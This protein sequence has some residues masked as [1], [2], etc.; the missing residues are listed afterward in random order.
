MR[1]RRLDSILAR[2]LMPAAWR[3]PLLAALLALAAHAASAQV[4]APPSQNS[5]DELL[6]AVVRLKT[7]VHPDARTAE[8]LG[9]ERDG[10]GIVIDSDGLIL[11]IGYLMVEAHAAQVIVN[12]GRVVPANVVGYDH[13][14]GFGLLRATE[15]LKVKPMAIGK[16]ADLKERDQ[17]LAASFGGRDGVAPAV[18]VSRREFVGAWEYLVDAAIFTAPTHSHWSGA[19]LISREGKLVGIGSLVVADA[20]GNG[21]GMA[22]NMYVPIDLLPPILADLIADGHAAGP[23]RPWIGLSTNELAGTLVVGRVTPGGPAEKAGLERGAVILAVA[24]EK[25]KDLADFYRKVWATGPAG[26]TVALDVAQNGTTRRIEI[27]SINRTDHL[28]LKSTY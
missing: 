24:G 15:P 11:T 28:R 5:L 27:Q 8:T 10:S 7:S 25:P 2:A 16:A 19:A 3:V 14:T 9:R 17:V 1:N 6:S 22:G 4:P 12:G 18:V 13:D 20:L 26:A 23:P 21:G